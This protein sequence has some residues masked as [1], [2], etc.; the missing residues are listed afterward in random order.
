[1]NA[2]NLLD[3]RPLS[4]GE[5]FDRTF[6]LF[7]R[8]FVTFILI[9]IIMQLP[10][11]VLQIASALLVN[12]LTNNIVFDPTAQNPFLNTE[13]LG[14]TLLVSFGIA[15]VSFI[16]TQVGM[17]A[18]TQAVAD[19]YLGRKVSFDNAFSRMG[20]T[21]FTLILASFVAG[22]FIFGLTIPILLVSF[23]PCLGAL[24]ALVGFF[25]IGAIASILVS[26]L[27]PVVVLE[28][29][30]ALEAV[31]RA[32]TLSRLRFWWVLGYLVL[33]TILT[34]VIIFGPSAVLGFALGTM[35]GGTS[36]LVQSIVQQSA[37]LVLTA[38]FLPIR[39]AA[40][41]LMYFDLRIRFEGFDLMVLAKAGE[42]ASNNA[43]DLPNQSL[44]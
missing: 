41:T 34:V 40:I 2:T 31:K 27:P 10:V 42:S 32:W 36:I 19:S 28:R 15:F 30:G 21:W 29:A 16:V 20:N 5:L 17:A 7:R 13:I 12:N 44:L 1:M 3:L 22:L 23:I 26:L 35:L 37:T 11:A 38:V 18:L 39:I 4:I 8:H 25:F 9:A 6:R 24:V 43:S 33:L 14:P